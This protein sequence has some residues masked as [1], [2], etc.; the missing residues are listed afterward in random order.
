[1]L[2]KLYR[3]ICYKL[4]DRTWQGKRNYLTKNGAIIGEGTRLYCEISS[5]G[6]EPYLIKVGKDCVFANGVHLF[7]H[8][9]G[10]NV[11]NTLNM[12]KGKKMGKYAPVIV[13]DN[14][15]I[16]SNAMIMPGVTIGDNVIIGAGAIVTHDIPS[17]VVAVGIPA[18]PIKSIEE[19]YEAAIS[20]GD[21]YCFE[22]K[23]PTEKISFL[24][25]LV[26]DKA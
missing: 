9:G 8:D 6:T 5:F 12:F 19:Y 17:N 24:K 4:A 20:K 7:T 2:R 3:N 13:G 26:K 10:I 14:V 15:Y 23:T 25:A 22:G 16:G 1:M 18:K 21:L 11:L